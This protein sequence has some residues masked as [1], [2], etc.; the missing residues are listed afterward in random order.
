M[1]RRFYVMHISIDFQCFIYLV[2][3]K[4][5][6]SIWDVY[7]RKIEIKFRSSYYYYLLVISVIIDLMEND[8]YDLIKLILRIFVKS[9]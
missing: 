3:Q 6:R 9:W 8:K 2:K 5:I 7:L 1:V 4:C